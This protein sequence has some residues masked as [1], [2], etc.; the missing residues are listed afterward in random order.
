MHKKLMSIP[1]A[2]LLQYPEE[3]R[4]IVDPDGH[5]EPAIYLK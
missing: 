1:F 5:L 4:G 3:M 2:A